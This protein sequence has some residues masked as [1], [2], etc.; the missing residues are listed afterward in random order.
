MVSI[1][2][3]E[4]SYGRKV[5]LS[6]LNLQLDKGNIYGLLGRNGA[7]KTTLLKL[8]SGEL[9][10][11][12]GEIRVLGSIPAKRTPALLSDIFYIPEEFTL[13]PASMEEYEKIMSPFYRGFS[14]ERFHRYLNEFELN[15]TRDKLTKMS[16][17]QKKKFLLAFGLASGTSLL[18]LD[19]PTNGL[20][21]PSKTQFRRTVASALGNEQIIL[22]STHQVRDM[23]NLIDPLIIIDEG[24]LRMKASLEQISRSYVMEQLPRGDVPGEALYAEDVPGG[25]IIVR[26]R[27]AGDVETAMDLEI[28]FNFIV[29]TGGI[30]K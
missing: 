3:L 19:E 20:D 26:K 15:G 7:G 10:H 18:L 12:T 11:R 23:E 9:F 5:V 28:L 4:F 2:S 27:R 21:I 29:K 30:Y 24:R 16:Y 1:K 13:P 22:I 6:D 25:Q 14:P 8:I 17:G